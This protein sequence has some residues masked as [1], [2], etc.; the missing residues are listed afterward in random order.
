MARQY[1]GRLSASGRLERLSEVGLWWFTEGDI[2]VVGMAGNRLVAAGSATCSVRTSNA[3]GA[4]G[5]DTAMTG[6]G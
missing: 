2:D 6:L 5:G 1:L 4:A 3:S